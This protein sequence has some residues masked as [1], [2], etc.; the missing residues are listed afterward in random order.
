MNEQE[1]KAIVEKI[2]SADKVIHSQ[3][4]NVEWKPPSDPIFA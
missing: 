2:I 3:Q 1:A 4:M